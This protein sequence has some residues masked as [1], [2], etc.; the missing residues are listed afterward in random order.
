[1]DWN[2][3]G[4]RVVCIQLDDGRHKLVVAYASHSNNKMKAKY[5]SYEREDWILNGIFINTIMSFFPTRM[6]THSLASCVCNGKGFPLILINIH[7]I[8]FNGCVEV[9]ET[10]YGY[11]LWHI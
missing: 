9:L 1:M 11:E 8:S 10:P 5:S 4:L 2:T 3:L 7:T 6:L